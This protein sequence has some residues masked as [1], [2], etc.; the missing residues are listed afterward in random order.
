MITRVFFVRHG[1][2]ENPDNIWYGR[3]PEFPL[4]KNGKKQI[5]KTAQILSKENITAIYASPLLRT[6]QSA[7]IISKKLGL[8]ISYSDYIL[9][10]K[11]TFQGKVN[12]Y[13]RSHTDNFNIFTD[14]TID[15]VAQRM[16]K[17]ID[18]III[19]HKEQNIVIVTHGDPIMIVKA[20]KEGLLME[21]NS[22]RPLKGYIQPGEIYMAE[23]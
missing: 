21:I 18:E 22:L 16:K 12:E 3:L 11:S 9:E 6:K 15:Q 8:S 17:F 20:Q 13:I 19:K 14:E 4:S 5:E 2:V 7:E 10:I 23:F 1:E